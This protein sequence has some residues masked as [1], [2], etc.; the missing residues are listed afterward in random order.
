MLVRLEVAEFEVPDQ[1]LTPGKKCY[2]L[3]EQTF[4]PLPGRA[5][6]RL[7][8]QIVAIDIGEGSGAMERVWQADDTVP[9]LQAL[10]TTAKV[11]R[12]SPTRIVVQKPSF[13]GRL[14]KWWSP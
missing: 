10:S 11:V 3:M 2:F 14:W 9:P 13:L 12:V 5:P 7:A 8:A 4:V 6:K 1:Y